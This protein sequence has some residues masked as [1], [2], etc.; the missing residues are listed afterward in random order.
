MARAAGV[1]TVSHC[2]GTPNFDEPAIIK[3][4]LMGPEHEYIHCT[5]V[6]KELFD[7]IAATGGHVSIATSIEMQMGHAH[8]PFQECLDRGIRPSL[9]VDVECNM[10]SDSFTQMRAAFT[11]QRAMVNERAILGEK[12][13]PPL[14]TCR[15]VI[16]FATIEGAKCAHVESKVGTL[17]PGKEADII[18]L[19]TGL[20]VAP[21]NNVP[22]AIVTLM[23]TSNVVNVFIAGKVMKWQG[24]MVGVDVNKVVQDAS[25]AAEGLIARS[26]YV[27]NVFDT[28]CPGELFDAEQRAKVSLDVVKRGR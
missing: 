11:W 16:E 1:P 10:T 26:G 20:N 8:P 3:S 13:V 4:G 24:Q 15:E 7:A 25:K 12:N 22:G 23:D 14:L 21:L 19:S 27:N 5:R 2:Q 28:C 6:S 17:T 9:S 18:M